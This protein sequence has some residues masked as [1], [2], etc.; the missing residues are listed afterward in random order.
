[1]LALLLL[2]ALLLA[3][4]PVP[5]SFAQTP[6]SPA[7]NEK[8]DGSHG[9]RQ[10]VRAE[11]TIHLAGCVTDATG[12]PATGVK[13][14][15]LGNEGVQTQLVDGN[16]C[17]ALTAANQNR[18]TIY[19]TYYKHMTPVDVSSVSGADVMNIAEAELGNSD[20]DEPY[21]GKYYSYGYN[22]CSEFVSWVYW[23]AGEPFTGGT[24]DGGTAKEAWNMTNTAR[25]LAGFGRNT[26]WDFF[27]RE[28]IPADVSPQAGDYVFFSN[29]EGVDRAH[30]GL[31]DM[32][33]GD[34]MQTIEGNYNDQVSR[35]TRADWRTKSSGSTI[36]RGI[37]FRRRISS[38]TFTPRFFHD[39][40]TES[41]TA[42]FVMT[43]DHAGAA[44]SAPPQAAYRLLLQE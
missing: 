43:Q 27:A 33:V 20:S 23:Q 38:V 26:D 39:W 2:P 5:S 17:Y 6:P 34:D 18:Y 1:M 21:P 12:A 35:V 29:A 11:E 36:V 32:I 42:D 15:L 37:G 31:V 10:L 25:V 8:L 3:G 40:L 28:D 19:P 44:T 41:A 14:I 30:S 16:G 7:H 22:W 9:E 13:I 24:D 4:L